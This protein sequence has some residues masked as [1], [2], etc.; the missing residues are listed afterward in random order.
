MKL[1]SWPVF[2]GTAVSIAAMSCAEH[3][4][5]LVVECLNNEEISY[6]SDVKPIVET[7]CTGC[8]NGSI[9]A[10]RN[11]L[12]FSNFQNHASEVRRRVTLPSDHPDHMPRGGSLSSD[13]I[14][15]IICWVDQGAQN[16]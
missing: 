11:W 8:H 2:I 1:F 6:A 10:D 9:G 16:N 5:P 7:V 12:V 15:T 14:Q 4:I 3:D 13:E